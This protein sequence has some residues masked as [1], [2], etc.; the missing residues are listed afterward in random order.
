MFKTYDMSSLG[1]Y[2]KNIRNGMNFTQSEVADL[3]NINIE[4]LRRIENGKVTPKYE[5][6]EI[7][8]IVYREDLMSVFSM[9]RSSK[10]L[11]ELYEKIDKAI[12]NHNEDDLIDLEKNINRLEENPLDMKLVNVNELKQL[13]YFV[14]GIRGYY[15][16][17]Y[18]VGIE[19]LLKA[20]KISHPKFQIE[21]PS[22]L[23]MN[24]FETRIVLIMSLC[25]TQQGEYRVAID[26][27]TKLLKL[28]QANERLDMAGI[29]LVIKLYFNISYNYYNINEHMK[30][31]K[32]TDLAIKFCRKHHSMYGLYTLYYRRAIAKFRI[33]NKGYKNDLKYCYQLLGI[34]GRNDLIRLYKNI[35]KEQHGIE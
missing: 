24:M 32:Y 29:Q 9:Y 14:E 22:G 35:T 3:A 1:T 33:G 20:I 11:F 18:N 7:L 4:T 21:N 15:D 16:Q 8:S 5:T 10:T 30:T 34:L 31:I 23:K 27:M 6:I 25:L 17:D 13:R 2:L 19:R 12:I 26:I 28:I